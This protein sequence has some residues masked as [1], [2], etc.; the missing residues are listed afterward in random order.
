MFVCVPEIA[1]EGVVVTSVGKLVMHEAGECFDWRS[2]FVG[3]LVVDTGSHATI[4][5]VYD[6]EGC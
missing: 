5:L 6:S 1:Q 4:L 3:A 2:C